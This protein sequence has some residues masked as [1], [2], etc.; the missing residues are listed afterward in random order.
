MARR[1]KNGTRRNHK[2]KEGLPGFMSQTNGHALR[3]YRI[4]A[5]PI[6][7][8]ILD[9]L[10]LPEILKKHLPHDVRTEVPHA[11]TLMV[12]LT[13]ILVSREPVYGVGEWARQY[14]P[15]LMNLWVEDVELLNDDRVGRA[16]GHL[17]R[18]GSSQLL[19]D[20]VRQAI[21]EFGLDL[22]ELHND[23]TSISLYGAYE[24]AITEQ[25]HDGKNTTSAITWG[26]SKDHRPDLKQLLFILTVTDDGGVPVFFNSASGNVVDD[27]THRQTWDTMKQLV[28]S[29]DFLY[30]ADC[31]LATSQNMRHLHD[32]DGKFVTVLPATRKEDD[33]FR[34]QLRE[35]PGEVKWQALY[36]VT[37]DD[38]EVI[39][40]LSMAQGEYASAEG[41][42]ILWYKSTKKAKLDRQTRYRKSQRAMLELSSLK[43]R[44]SGP[45]TRFRERKQVE[46]AVAKIKD[47]LGVGAW[48][49]VQILEYE[50]EKYRQA[51]RGRPTAK[52]AY[53]K[54]LK[55]RY[56]LTWSV[57]AKLE[58]E[59][60][61]DD[62]IFPLITNSLSLTG[63]EVLRAY[64][65][66][67]IIEKRFSQ[68]KTD[69]CVAP[70]YL[71]NVER[72]EGLLTVYFFVLMV[73][74]LL[75]RELRRAMK[76][77]EIESLPFYPEQRE[78]RRPT[79]RRL[80][81]IFEPIQRHTY[82]RN[83]DRDEEPIVLVT[84]LTELQEQVLKLLKIDAS[85][86]GH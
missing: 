27:Q 69:F 81:D 16:L 72:I 54:E 64:K 9:R 7:H 12:L 76:M 24:D 68:L 11:R 80:L 30:V 17:F 21:D 57:N 74:T 45:K 40:Q 44:L 35:S 13:N 60:Q 70:I 77:E 18:H 47:E 85:T 63:E 32:R 10:R 8:S 65:R 42:R 33:Q 55:K 41:F 83:L 82:V 51:G 53:R 3:S 67:P 6:L 58:L 86:Y 4:G 28:G 2:K 26:F 15:D 29:S 84:E 14:A 75:E 20:V 38:D 78:C 48:L 31:K 66:Q 22:S 59:E 73:Q 39:D 37:N 1:T 56:T 43:D 52:T 62:G 5:L 79:T 25:C 36:E 23:S 71:K 46:E 34:R 50:E 61:R 19:L 49:E